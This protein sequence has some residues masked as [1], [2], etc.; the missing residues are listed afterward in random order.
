M[1]GMDNLYR[2][3]HLPGAGRIEL[4]G[5]WQGEAM[6]VVDQTLGEFPQ[7]EIRISFPANEVVLSV[8]EQV[9]GTTS[10]LRGHS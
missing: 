5:H 2:G 6:F 7:Q 10:E 8:K 3:T 4:R 1:I 9:F